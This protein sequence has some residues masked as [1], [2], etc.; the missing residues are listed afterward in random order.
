MGGRGDEEDSKSG[1]SDQDQA[2]ERREKG[3]LK[4]KVWQ[5]EKH[6]SN[7]TDDLGFKVLAEWKYMSGL[8]HKGRS[9]SDIVKLQ[10]YYFT[11]MHF[12]WIK[13]KTG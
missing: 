6:K 13:F 9:S 2:Y 1:R 10:K 12:I 5:P 11:I 3:G 7:A 8:L 4:A